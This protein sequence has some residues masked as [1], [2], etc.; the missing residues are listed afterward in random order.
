MLLPRPTVVKIDVEGLEGEVIRG[1]HRILGGVRALFVEIHFQILDA[2]GM[3]QT[4]AAL[5]KELRGLGF[6]RIEWPDAS[7][8]AVFRADPDRQSSAA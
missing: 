6:S 2:R 7:H 1:M 8:L 4:P 3:R 5:V